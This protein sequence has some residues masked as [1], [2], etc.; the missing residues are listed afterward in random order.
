LKVES[1]RD[2]AETLSCLRYAE[3]GNDRKKNGKKKR[4]NTEFT[5]EHRGHRDFW[6]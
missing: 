2:N 5:E 4:I 3:F 1:V 6:D